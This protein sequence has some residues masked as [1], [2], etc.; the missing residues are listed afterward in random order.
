[1]VEPDASLNPGRGYSCLLNKEDFS[2]SWLAS[3]LYFNI[4][5]EDGMRPLKTI[6]EENLEIRVYVNPC[7]R[8]VEDARGAARAVKRG[9]VTVAR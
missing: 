8:L 9:T 2:H 1:M 7:Q 3:L 4:G 5:E 6:S